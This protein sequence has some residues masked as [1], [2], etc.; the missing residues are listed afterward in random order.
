[1]V[2]PGFLSAEPC[3]PWNVRPSKNILEGPPW[4]SWGSHWVS[5]TCCLLGLGQGDQTPRQARGDEVSEPHSAPPQALPAA[6]FSMTQHDC[7]LPLALRP[8]KDPR[9]LRGTPPR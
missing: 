9:R 4:R 8:L 5:S 1:M 7:A 2:S 6:E 3:D